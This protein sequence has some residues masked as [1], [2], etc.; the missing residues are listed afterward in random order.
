MMPNLR[1]V[2]SRLDDPDVIPFPS[3]RF[4]SPPARVSDDELD[5]IKRAELA[6]DIA[7]QQLDD[8][9]ELAEVYRF[10]PN[11]EGPTAA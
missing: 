4:A 7:Q 1:L 9:K 8:L 10:P 11:D 2:D 5:S 3:H 6:L